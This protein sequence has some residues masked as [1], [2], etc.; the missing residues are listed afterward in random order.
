MTQQTLQ[1]SGTNARGTIICWNFSI[2]HIW[3]W[4]E[5]ADALNDIHAMNSAIKQ[6]IKNPKGRVQEKVENST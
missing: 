6:K 4:S 2:S 5:G 1:I 3:D